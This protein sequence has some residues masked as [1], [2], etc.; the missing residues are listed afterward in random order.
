MARRDDRSD[1]NDD[2]ARRERANRLRRR[3]ADLKKATGDTPERLP[4]ES[5]AEYVQR[6]MNELERKE[7]KV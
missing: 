3:I 6:R 2:A 4:G 7:P 1:R 5:E